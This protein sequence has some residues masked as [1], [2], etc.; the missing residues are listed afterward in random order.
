MATCTEALAEFTLDQNFEALPQSVVAKAKLLILDGL[1]LALAAAREDF[2]ARTLRALCALGQSPDATVIGVQE[3]VPVASAPLLNG[4][5]IHA[6]DF[7]DTHHPLVIHN[8]SVVMPAALASAEWLGLSGKDFITACAIGFEVSLRVAR[9]PRVHAIHGRGYHPTAVCGVF[10]AAAAAGRLMGLTHQQLT[11]AFGLAGSQGSGNMEW[12]S[13]GSWSKRFQPGWAA[14]GALVGALLARE[15]FTAPRTALEGSKGFYATHV[16][17][18]N[19][20]VTA[21]LDGMGNDW[22]LNRAEF[23]PYPC[24]GALQATVRACVNLHNRYH[25]DG[26]DIVEVECRLRMGDRPAQQGGEQIFA[27]QAPQGEYGAHFS[28]PYLAAVALLKGRL[29]LA[30]FDAEA[31]NDRAVLN[32]SSKI[33]REDDPHSGRP[34]YASGHVF[35]RTRDGKVYEERQH[36]HPGHVEN[37]LSA[38]EVA[39]K[40][41]YNALR[42]VSREKAEA[43]MKQTMSIERMPNVRE[44]T[45]QLRF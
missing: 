2:A 35:V 38:V 34:K 24:A 19:F 4:M 14:H 1:G 28:T 23:K 42:M 10:G 44:L 21:A 25:L 45:E 6:F 37:P 22:E 7:D 13:D 32:L 40:Y 33:R 3:K 8:T 5:L 41:R 31:L 15:G 12:Q 16:G 26:D 20:D 9:G 39:E 11:N 43:L 27:E 36:I 18:E 30:D 17:Q 29:A